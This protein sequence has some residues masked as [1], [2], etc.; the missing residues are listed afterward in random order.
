[1]STDFVKCPRTSK[2]REDLGLRAREGL[3]AVVK[4]AA[5]SSPHFLLVLYL[6]QAKINSIVRSCLQRA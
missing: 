4:V 2:A 5:P 3:G 6:E 1:M